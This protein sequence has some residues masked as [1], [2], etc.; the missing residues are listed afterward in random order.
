MF[1]SLTVCTILAFE[2]TRKAQ[3]TVQS[4]VLR[5]GFGFEFVH[6]GIRNGQC[7]SS[8][9]SPFISRIQQKRMDRSLNLRR[10][11]RFRNRG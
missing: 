5:L 7:G 9:V 11:R 3:H 4:G 6:P 2:K 1:N 8:V 10:K